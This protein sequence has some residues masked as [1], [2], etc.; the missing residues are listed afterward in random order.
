MIGW[1]TLGGMLSQMSICDPELQEWASMLNGDPP[2]G[3]AHGCAAGGR[4]QSTVADRASEVTPG[5]G[6][7]YGDAGAG[8]ENGQANKVDVMEIYSPPRITV[9]AGKHGLEPGD[10]L[11]LVTGYDFNRKE[12]RDKA[13]TIIARDK[14]KLVVGSPECRMFS[15]LHNLNAWTAERQSRL[16]NAR[17]HLEFICEVHEHQVTSE[18]WFLHEHPIAATS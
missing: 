5:P 7:A 10:A 2:S 11:D 17:E 14:P 1:N 3:V 13:W 8:P 6:V 16:E 12:D 4:L 9:H 18:R 15:A